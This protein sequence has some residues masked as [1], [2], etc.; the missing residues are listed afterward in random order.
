M[1]SAGAAAGRWKK[2]S[3]GNERRTTVIHSPL[4]IN[5]FQSVISR[6]G[7]LAD[8]QVF[9]RRNECQIPSHSFP[10]CLCKTSPVSASEDYECESN[11]Q[12]I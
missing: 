1:L 5:F 9:Q 11:Y 6:V 12:R 3:R 4:T 7:A 2:I 10:S 8:V